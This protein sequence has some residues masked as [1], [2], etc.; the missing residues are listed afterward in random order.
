MP[1][2]PVPAEARPL[3]DHHHHLQ[4][5]PDV[6][7]GEATRSDNTGPDLLPTV[8]CSLAEHGGW[9][10]ASMKSVHG[11]CRNGCSEAGILPTGCP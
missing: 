8:C 9:G 1:T 6:P 2:R 11:L 10:G 7:R 3:R 5:Q 4:A